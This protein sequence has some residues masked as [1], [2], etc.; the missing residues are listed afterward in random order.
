MLP[1][2]RCTSL[3]FDPRALLSNWGT[4]ETKWPPTEDDVARFASIQAVGTAEKRTD[5]SYLVIEIIITTFR[6]YS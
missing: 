2:M 1:S 3:N 5:Y 4:W 6:A